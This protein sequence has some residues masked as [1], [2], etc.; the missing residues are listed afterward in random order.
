M[1]GHE[2]IVCGGA[3]AS[4]SSR[5][6][7]GAWEQWRRKKRRLM[8]ATATA[9]AEGQEPAALATKERID[10]VAA[11][12]AVAD[13]QVALDKE[14]EDVVAA[15]TAAE[16]HTDTA[17]GAV[18]VGTPFREC[19]ATANELAAPSGAPYLLLLFWISCA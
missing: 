10:K 12:T 14:E 19:R 2:L 1:Y 16:E 17:A 9:E 11:P 4:S 15:A 8:A 3:E 6:R 18:V 13:A 7:E 5:K